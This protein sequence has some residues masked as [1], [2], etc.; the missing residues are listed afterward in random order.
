MFSRGKGFL[1]TVKCQM[2]FRIGCVADYIAV[3]AAVAYLI[4]W[5]VILLT[6]VLVAIVLKYFLGPAA[7][8]F[9]NASICK[10][11][12][13]ELG[14]KPDKDDPYDLQVPVSI[15]DQHVKANASMFLS[16]PEVAAGDRG[17]FT[18]IQNE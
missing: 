15:F 6:A 18:R 11:W 1:A 12:R 9:N 3:M 13:E 4:G 2:A 14:G 16:N 5:E 7:L 17:M 10:Y 8:L